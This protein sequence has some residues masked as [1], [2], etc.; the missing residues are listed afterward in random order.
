M[1]CSHKGQ[2]TY[3]L[4]RG[5]GVK[6]S[7]EKSMNFYR[8]GVLFLLNGISSLTPQGMTALHARQLQL[9]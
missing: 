3:T 9:L 4:G 6:V 8:M 1:H 7:E 2:T 5:E